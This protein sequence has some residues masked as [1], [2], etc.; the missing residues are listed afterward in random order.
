MNERTVADRARLTGLVLAR[1]ARS[2]WG[3]ALGPF[4]R[5]F[6]ARRRPPNRLLIAPQDIRTADPTVAADIYAGYFAFDGKVVNTHGRSPFSLPAPTA[7]WAEALAGFGWL[8]HLRAADTALARV[9]AR[10]LVGDWIN[11]YGRPADGPAWLP[12]V[13]A[14][15]VLSWLSQS[16]LILDGADGFFYRRFMRSLGRQAIMLQRALRGGGMTGETRLLTVLALTE[17]GL[18]AEA[19]GRLQRQAS[20][21]LVEEIGIQILADGGHVSRDPGILAELLLDLLPLRQAFVAAGVAPPPPLL[22]AIDRMMPMLRSFRHGDGTLALFNGMGVTK[23]D[24]LATVFAHDDA[25]GRALANAP[26]SGYQRLEANGTLLI[27]DSGCPP[28]VAFSRRAH[29]GT[30]AFELSVGTQRVIINCGSP[31]NAAPAVREAARATAAHSTLVLNHRSSSRF[32]SGSRLGRWLDGV[33]YSGPGQVTVGRTDAATAIGVEVS[34]DGYLAGCGLLHRRR[35]VLAAA[36]DRLD[37]EDLLVP[38]PARAAAA[39]GPRSG[40]KSRD[41]PFAIRFHMHHAL[42]LQLIRNGTA[43]VVAFPTGDLWQFEAGGLSIAIEESIYFAS[44]EGPRRIEQFVLRS[45]T[46]ETTRV[47]WSMARGGRG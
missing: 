47:A 31:D 4:H 7:S 6:S 46:G 21:R 41:L 19:F 18:C 12:P 14:R 38:S 2:V 42:R 27:L 5:L 13:V 34:H 23:L 10:A 32:S 37:G 30:L 29:A 22:N 26:Y 1:G 20:R 39:R 16:P 24:A 44:A 9:N 28:P 11:L 8:R 45:H 40:A 17:L 25:G 36:G 33:L 35:L 43:A 3:G 15:R